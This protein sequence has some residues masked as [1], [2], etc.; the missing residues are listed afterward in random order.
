MTT[1][2]FAKRL[3][4]AGLWVFPVREDKRPYGSDEWR[5]GLKQASNDPWYVE[6][7][8]Q[9]YPKALIGIHCG[10]SG[11]VVLDID[12]KE[13]AEG[14]VLLSGYDSLDESWLEVP[15]TF[16]YPS[17]GGLGTHKVY[18]APEG[19]NFNGTGRYRGML[20]VDRRAG[21]SYIVYNS[22]EIP[23]RSTLTPAPE[24]LCDAS[25][26]RTADKFEGTVA[27]WY[28]TLEEGEPSLIV[29]A[30]MDRTRKAFEHGGEDFDH[31]AVIERQFEAIRLGAEGHPG[32]P[33]LLSLVEELFF[34]RT[35]DH[36]R[37]EEEW[38]HEW[39]EGLASGVQKYGD[40][41]QLRKDLPAYDLNSV[42]GSVPNRLV[43]GAPGTKEDFSALLRALLAATT[44][45]LLVTSILWNSAVTRDLARE[46]GLEFVHRRVLDA[47]TRPEPV[48]ENP[49]LPTPAEPGDTPKVT[50]TDT[51]EVPGTGAGFLTAE[52]Q[53]YVEATDT[54]IKAYCRASALKG[55]WVPAYDIP[56]AWT[57]LSMAVGARAVLAHNSLGTNVWFIEMGDTGTGKTQSQKFLRAVL[58]QVLKDDES[59]YNVGASSSPA[60]IH[61]ELLLR[62]G[63]ASMIHHDEA[64]TFFS[65][66]T[67]TEW[68]KTLEHMFSSFYDG[69]VEPSNKVRLPKELRGKSAVTSFNLNMSATPDKLLSL[70][71]TEMFETGFLSRVNWT[72][73]P[74]REKTDEMFDVDETDVDAVARAHPVVYDL[75]ADLCHVAS[76]IPNRVV[77]RGSVE[78]RKR[79]A[80]AAKKFDELARSE[81]RYDVLRGPL[82]RLKETLV[83]CAA[84]LALYRG[85]TTFTE[86]DALIAISYGVEWYQTMVRVVEETSSS[87]FA[88]DLNDIEAYVRSQPE[89]VSEA[90][91]NHR[92]RNMIHRSPRELQDRLD[93][94]IRSGRI[95]LD[96]SNDRVK[97]IINGTAE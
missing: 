26:V 78:A 46:W 17:I 94:L 37:P 10:L 5:D 29:R 58:N 2:Q 8:F 22:E 19:A 86:G 35:G 84:L 74:L 27:E 66:L 62:D 50:P 75:A 4:E 92:F 59:Y 11:L 31:A 53:E 60:A 21:E 91:L 79:I 89:G 15:D 51:F 47:R 80:K 24:W 82:T 14:N 52:E 20:G 25:T 40:A 7:W 61:E 6:E 72:W 63:K 42:P 95:N 81:E 67:N 93:F 71:T 69:E 45:D 1:A 68:M 44:D 87:E 56:A 34:S 13:D 88:R 9:K 76:C 97:Y 41:I 96:R 54:F 70:V 77:V 73:A 16:S 55:F 33:Q 28:E 57:A 32:V 18:A 39:L 43:A 30:A 90:R 83:K 49:T 38:E 48:R 64:A 3:A 65:D 36:S 85:E 23:D 12:Q